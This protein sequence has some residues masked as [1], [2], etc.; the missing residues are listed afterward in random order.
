MNNDEWYRR[1]AEIR[2]QQDAQWREKQAQAERERQEAERKAW[3]D[4]GHASQNSP[5]YRT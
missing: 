4:G 2:A 1:Q 5:A 3:L